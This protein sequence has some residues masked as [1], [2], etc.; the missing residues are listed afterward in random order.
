[1]AELTD[2]DTLALLDASGAPIVPASEH[3]GGPAIGGVCPTGI[4]NPYPLLLWEAQ[5]S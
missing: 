5:V 4:A 1:M 3:R 2:R